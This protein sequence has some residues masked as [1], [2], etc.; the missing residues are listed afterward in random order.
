MIAGTGGAPDDGLALRPFHRL[1][2]LL[3]PAMAAATVRF[4]PDAAGDAFRGLYVTSEQA[5]A[6]LE[7]PPGAPLVTTDVPVHPGWDEITTL[8]EG[9]AWLRAA[10]GLGDDELDVVLLAMGP[11]VDLRYERL[12]GYLQDD[13]NRRHPTV[14][15]AL[16]ILATDPGRRLAARRLF[17]AD[18]PLRARRV[19]RLRADARA[20]A[21]PLLA[22]QLVLDPQIVDLLLGHTGL[23]AR[24]T[25]C[26]EL[27]AAHDL[28]PGVAPAELLGLASKGRPLRLYF[29]GPPGTGRRAA[30]EAVAAADDVPLLAVDLDRLPDEDDASGTVEVLLRAAS[31]EDALLYLADADALRSEP[32]AALRRALGRRLATHDGIVVVAGTRDWMPWGPRPLGVLTVPFERADVAVRREAW[33]RALDRHAASTTDADLDALAV[34]F[35]IG[36]DRIDDAVLTAHTAA[37][38]RATGATPERADLFAAARAQSRH[39]LGALA[40]RIE[41]VHGWRDIVLPPDALD[42]LHEL[43]DRVAYRSRVMDDWGF[44]ATMSLGTGISA[45]FA[46]PPGTGKTM[47]AEVLARELGLDLYKIDLAAVVSKYIGETEKNLERVFTAA[48]ETDAIL[49]FDEADALFGKRSEVRDARDRYANIEVAYLLQRMEQHDGLAILST[50]LR[51]NLDDAFTRRLAFVVTVLPRN[52]FTVITGVCAGHT[53]RAIICAPSN[54]R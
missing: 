22:H 36:P 53:P 14:D 34:T 47:A 48:A 46:G 29:Q 39:G 1:D 41:P 31:R 19:L 9:W 52:R 51:G 16:D 17:A 2:R 15:L 24:L 33:E 37:R 20:T 4:G 21:P 18:A 42:Q 6:L 44:G 30:A 3:A 8:D 27:V 23:D 5:A 38:L 7:R 45:L 11:E 12:Y 49:L 50:N 54:A 10:Y 35:R 43:C 28:R 40:R 13:V 32:R 25:E 26:A